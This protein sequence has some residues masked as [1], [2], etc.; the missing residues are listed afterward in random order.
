MEKMN[1]RELLRKQVLE[2]YAKGIE[3]YQTQL[4]NIVD[5]DDINDEV[6][7]NQIKSL[8]ELR[9]KYPKLTRDINDDLNVLLSQVNPVD[10]KNFNKINFLIRNDVE[11][12]YIEV[13]YWLSVFENSGLTE[14]QKQLLIDIV[15]GFSYKGKYK[16]YGFLCNKI[17]KSKER[18]N[19]MSNKKQFNEEQLKK[20]FPNF[21][22]KENSYWD[23]YLNYSRKLEIYEQSVAQSKIRM[24]RI[25]AL[26]LKAS[27]FPLNLE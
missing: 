27:I 22:A 16:D 10:I 3:V 6:I 1:K 12:E 24:D 26:S 18:V 2:L 17:E 23:E 4:D 8:K 11:N 7:L 9:S 25:R 14:K 19:K 20:L 13:L 5:I 15:E 21:Y